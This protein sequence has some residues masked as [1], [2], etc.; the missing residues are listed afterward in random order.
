MIMFGKPMLSVDCLYT[1][2]WAAFYH[3]RIWCHKRTSKLIWW[4][5]NKWS[6]DTFSQSLVLLWLPYVLHPI[7]FLLVLQQLKAGLG[8]FAQQKTGNLVLSWKRLSFLVVC[9]YPTFRAVRW[10]VH[11]ESQSD[12]CRGTSRRRRTRRSWRR[13]MPKEP[14][15]FTLTLLV[16]VIFFLTLLTSPLIV[17]FFL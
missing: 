11:P 9:L 12:D 15:A 1:G 16:Q 4:K 10:I 8:H 2:N 6:R 14:P 3:H 17:I 13:K 5:S 7:S